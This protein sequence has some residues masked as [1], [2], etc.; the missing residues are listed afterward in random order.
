MKA[1]VG[2][3]AIVLAGGRSSRF[4]SDKLA[5]ELNGVSILERAMRAAGSVS[6]EV[7]VVGL[8]NP[9]MV[10]GG[11]PCPPLRAVP[12]DQPHAGP[13]AA[14]VGALRE[15]S[16]GLAI[17]VG[18]DM[19]EL[20]PAVLEAMLEQLT[21]D[22]D[23]DA[24]L[25]EG[26]GPAPPRR[27]VLPVALRVAPAAAAAAAAVQAGDRSLTRL[28]DRLRSAEIPAAAWLAIDPT[29]RTLLD[30]DRPVDLLRIRREFR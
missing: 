10:P 9:S 29:G 23:L 22:E 3:T 21:S 19:P 7:I 20:A 13:L 1:A 8:P 5:V 26:L 15:T 11:R 16:T 27:Q 14:L 24:A 4:G 12:D 25:L 30:V 28:V 2:V 18:G 17:V 6:D